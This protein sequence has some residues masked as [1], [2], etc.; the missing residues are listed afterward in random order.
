MGNYCQI[1]IVKHAWCFTIS[2]LLE[3]SHHAIC[4]SN[5]FITNK[6]IFL[7]IK[8]ILASHIMK[9]VLTVDTNQTQFILMV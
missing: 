8:S 5:N 6:K 2:N 3:I 1:N 4:A 9:S 7:Y